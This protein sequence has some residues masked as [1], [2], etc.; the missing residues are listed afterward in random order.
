[1]DNILNILGV[2]TGT[3]SA[4]GIV[5]LIGFWKGQVDSDRVEWKRCQKEYPLAEL[6]TMAKTMW[7]IYVVDALHQRPDLANRNSPLKLTNKGKD[8]I[9]GEI[10]LILDQVPGNPNCKEDIANGWL[11]VKSVGL[12][13]I[14][15]MAKD[16]GLSVQ[17]SI[18]V[19]STY[20]DER[21]NH[22]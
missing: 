22:C 4:L 15:K 5:Y 8:L 17:E 19:L 7:D 20:L 1:M 21:R 2:I 18:A 12:E 10:K 11:A 13:S 6:W 14:D 16:T 9:P 3:I